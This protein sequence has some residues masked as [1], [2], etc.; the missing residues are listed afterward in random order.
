M[1]SGSIK[2]WIGPHAYTVPFD[3]STNGFV[4]DNVQGAIEEIKEELSNLLSPGYS[5]GKSGNVTNNTWLWR[6]GNIPSDKTGYTLG[7]ANP[8]LYRINCGSE[9][10]DTYSISV[11]MHDGSL[12]NLLLITTVS[13]VNSRRQTFY[14]SFPLTQNRQIAVRLTSGSAKNLGVDLQA[15]GIIV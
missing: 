12:I 15:T 8:V 6:E 9:Q 13:I 10:N 7:A 5:F 14:V 2:I 1:Q 4:S 3:N 11:Y